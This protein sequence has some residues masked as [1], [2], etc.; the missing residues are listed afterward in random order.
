MLLDNVS[1]FND[2]VIIYSVAFI[3]VTVP[4]VWC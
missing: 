2:F 1:E 3:V 4:I